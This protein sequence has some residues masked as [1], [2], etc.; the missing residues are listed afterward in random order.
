MA[1]RIFNTLTGEKEAFAP[2]RPPKV[3][4]YVCGI[5]SYDFSH[6]GHARVY[7]AFDVAVRVL[8]ARGFELTYVRNFTDIDD[9]IIK[10]ASE[11]GGG[12]GDA[13]R[14]LHRG[15][16][17][18]TWRPWRYFRPTSSPGSPRTF[19]KSWR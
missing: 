11:L 17:S 16:P 18:R 8:R 2:L 14:A 19:R 15:L 5:T 1:L 7:V 3:G 4:I 12:A 10:R 13:E 9:K 6:I